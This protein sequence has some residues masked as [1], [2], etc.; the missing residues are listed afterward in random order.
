VPRGLAG[1]DT[2]QR[3]EQLLVPANI[4]P[5]TFEIREETRNTDHYDALHNITAGYLMGDLT[6]GPWRIIGGARVEKSEQVVNTFEPFLVNPRNVIAAL[7]DTDVLP[8]IGVARTLRHDS[9]T[10]R[11]G[12][13]RTVARPQFRELSP[14]EFTNITGGRSTV[15]FPD[16]K[17]T[18]ISNYDLRYEWFVSPGELLA[19]SVFHK[20]FKN[21]IETVVQAQTTLINSFRNAEKARNTGL[22][23][24]LRKNLGHLWT[25][26]D[27]ISLTTN[28]TFVRSRVNIGEENRELLTNDER[29][30]VGQSENVFNLILN[31][32]VPRVG[33]EGRMLFNYTGERISEVGA[34]GLP[35]IIQ[36]GYPVLDILFARNF[37]TENRM[38]FEFTIENAL[39]RQTDFRLDNQAQN[40]FRNGRTFTFGVSYRIY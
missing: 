9:M 19:V 7:D 14:F 12:F 33:V 3:P 30:L 8:S 22:E 20:D 31:Y 27:N 32:D 15:G 34:L 16:L 10:V 36:H 29:P 17:R 37:G 4:N 28:Y 23:I 40:V 1:L 6:M 26:V 2:S 38:R 39:N 24:E 13:S 21:P 11:L 25:A 5:D 18:L 35:D